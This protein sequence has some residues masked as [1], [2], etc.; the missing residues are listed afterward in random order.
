MSVIVPVYNA[1]KYLREC[2]DSIVAQK[3]FNELE[4]IAVDDGSKDSSGAI[5]NEYSDKYDNFI[6]IHQQNAGVSAARNAGINAASGEFIGFVDADDYIF[7]EMFTSMLSKADEHSADMVACDYKLECEEQIIDMYAHIPGEFVHYREDILNIICIRMIENDSV[8]NIWNKIFK[9]EL[10][11]SYR[12][13]FTVGRKYGEDREFVLRYL[14]HCSCLAYAYYCGYFYRCVETSATKR[15]RTNYIDVIL[16]QYYSDIEL[17]ALVG[18]DSEFAKK[19]CGKST[20]NK[21][22]DTMWVICDTFMGSER[23]EIIRLELDNREIY[24]L[25]EE[26]YDDCF[27][28]ADSDKRHLMELMRDKKV[29]GIHRYIKRA[30]LIAKI[31]GLLRK[32][33]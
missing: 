14:A 8:N 30:K 1:E 22:I 10:V 9:T 4:V 16:E 20:V 7:P 24:A 17:F 3:N 31:K 21:Y 13:Y 25:F 5:C 2:F 28:S 26:R 32:V 18:L 12:L 29:N 11:K 33:G 6:V 19:A 23:D 15:K 27:A